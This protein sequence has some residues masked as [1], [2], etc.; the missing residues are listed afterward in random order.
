MTRINVVPVTE[1]VQEHLIAEYRELP[2]IFA[3]VLKAHERGP[4]WRARQ[5][6]FYTLGPGHVLFFYDKL[7]WLARRQR[8]LV[9]EMQRRGY[10]PQYTACLR[11]QWQHIPEGYW[12][13]YEPTEAA[14]A[15]NRERIS[16]RLRSMINNL[17]FFV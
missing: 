12:Q 15:T 8:H 4:E 3:L 5:P 11:R 6:G 10:K 7:T 17:P 9:R 16:T 2:R 1:L 13:D 14:M